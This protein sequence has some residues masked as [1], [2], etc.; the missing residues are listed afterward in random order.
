[1]SDGRSVSSGSDCQRD[2]VCLGLALLFVLCITS[3]HFFLNQRFFYVSDNQ[4]QFF[5]AFFEIARLIKAGEAPWISLHSWAG[6]NLI[7]EYQYGIFNPV[8]LLLYLLIS[9]LNDLAVA[10]Y[11][12]VSVNVLVC[13]AG[14]YWLSR[15][16]GVSAEYAALAAFAIGANNFL[17]Y[18]HAAY[19]LPQYLSFA[20]FPWAM[21]FLLRSASN[22][23]FVFASALATYMVAT[24]G[25]PNT[26]L[27]LALITILLGVLELYRSRSIG[28]LARIAI[29]PAL[30]IFLAAPALAPFVAHYL[31]S[32]R[33]VVSGI[34]E[35]SYSGT[36]TGLFNFAFPSFLD[37]SRFFFLDGRAYGVIESPIYFAAWFPLAA[38][39]SFRWERIWE[40]RAEPLRLLT[41]ALVLFFFLSMM[42]DIQPFRWSYKF[43]PF[44]HL[45]VVIAAAWMLS[46]RDLLALDSLRRRVLLSAFIFLFLLSTEYSPLYLS[47]HI[48]F[49]GLLLLGV[50]IWCFF[51]HGTDSKLA[52]GIAAVSVA[53]AV[54]TAFLWR[55]TDSGAGPSDARIPRNVSAMEQ[56][57]DGHAGENILD[58]S[59][60]VATEL[61]IYANQVPPGNVV[62][63]VRG[64]FI[65]GY[66]SLAQRGLYKIFCI[67]YV[68]SVCPGVAT[69]LFATDPR[70]RVS[71]ADLLHL[72]RIIVQKGAHLDDF[73][74][75]KTNDWV[76]VAEAPDS[77]TF[78]RQ[79]AL[80]PLAG[81]I[82][83]QPQGVRV[84][85][86]Q[87]VS[88]QRE[89][90]SIY[91]DAADFGRRVIFERAWYPGY[92][93][94]LDGR[95]IRVVAHAGFM[96]AAVVPPGISGSHTLTLAYRLPGA[97]ETFVV[98][99]LAFLIAAAI[100]FVPWPKRRNVLRRAPTTRAL[101]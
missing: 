7:G 6:G 70:T 75:A 48:F 38:A 89:V 43:I 84:M 55:T 34:G 83:W 28:V 93:A 72:D 90:H 101:F 12:F 37:V 56:V 30:G 14:V 2:L 69:R 40:K 23:K 8:S 26:V 33:A 87:E 74:N 22:V 39:I 100:S 32:D 94:R 71:Y 78:V 3:L 61:S 81:T 51:F 65:N 64:R 88:T 4:S 58:I 18:W 60:I 11:L 53:V 63:F 31:A 41:L 86:T 19:W 52:G 35:A 97:P 80:K 54:A 66:T 17:T 91:V 44:Y 27:A 47:Y 50:A 67:K 68:S 1:M 98:A 16:V 57:Y 95:R 77:Q 49:L 82:A 92:E 24:S 62:Y 59:T 76:K 79:R 73:L 42:P 25:Y 46:N 36:L 29:G 45:F 5:P 99:A 96:V 15:Q 9:N 10:S 13:V 20:W 85:S 21:L